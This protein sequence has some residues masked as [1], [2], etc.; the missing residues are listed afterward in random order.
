MGI[1]IDCDQAAGPAGPVGEGWIEI[2]S[3]RIGVDFQRSVGSCG[4][5]ED[6]VPIEI[7][8]FATLDQ[9]SRWVRNDVYVR[10]LEDA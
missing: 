10:I 2:E 8:A 9:A 7:S 5:L 3:S 6:A 1:A 4:F